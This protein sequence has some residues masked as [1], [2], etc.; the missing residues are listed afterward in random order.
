MMEPFC[1]IVSKQ[2]ASRIL[3]EILRWE[4]ELSV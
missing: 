2:S 3:P 1:A 4:A